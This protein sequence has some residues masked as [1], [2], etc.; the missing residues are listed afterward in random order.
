MSSASGSSPLLTFLRVANIYDLGGKVY[1]LKLSL[2]VEGKRY[3]LL[4]GGRRIHTTQ[5]TREKN[6]VPSQFTVTLRKALRTK[7]L[8]EIK[9]CGID[10]VVDICFRGAEDNHL[11]VELY[12]SG[13]IILT[14]KDYV[15]ITLLRT[16]KFDENVKCAPKEKYPFTQAAGMQIKPFAELGI[17]EKSL[18]EL[19]A[20][21]LKERQAAELLGE[22]EEEGK[23]DKRSKKKKR[24]NKNTLRAFLQV[25]APFINATEAEHCILSVGGNPGDEVAEDKYAILFKVLIRTRLS[26]R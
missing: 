15:I 18:K 16:H 23:T 19:Y 10:R 11:I 3:L 17:T 5:F 21:K 1:I 6:D 13:N 26:V 25:V 14:D 12:A 2:P 8:V 4:E 7:K 20:Q 22:E 9:Q 24:V